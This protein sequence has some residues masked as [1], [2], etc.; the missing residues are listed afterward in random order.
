MIKKLKSSNFIDVKE[1]IDRVNDN[2]KDFYFTNERNRLFLQNNDKL[3]KKLLKKYECFGCFEGDL[4]SMIVIFAEKGFRIYLKVLG[5][6][7]NREADLIKFILWK[8][9]NKDL[10]IK[11]KKSNPLVNKITNQFTIVGNRGTEVLLYRQKK[12]LKILNPKQGDLDE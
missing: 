1:F 4:Q 6:I 9:G 2:N 12:P 7:S 10:Y 5:K 11:L 3:I 8:I